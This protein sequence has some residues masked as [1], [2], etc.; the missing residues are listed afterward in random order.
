MK[1]RKF[2]SKNLINSNDMV[3]PL[4]LTFTVIIIAGYILTRFFAV[5][6]LEQTKEEAH[7]ITKQTV[8]G[9]TNTSYASKKINK[10][11]DEKIQVASKGVVRNQSRIS[12]E[13]LIGLAKDFE[14]DTLD[15]YN[16]QGVVIN[17]TTEEYL[18]WQ[19][20]EGHP[21]YDFMVSS[22][23]ELVEDIRQDTE[24]GIYYKFG[25]LKSLEGNFV[26]VGIIADKVN[27]LTEKFGIQNFVEE[28]ALGKD[29]LRARFIDKNLLVV[30]SSNKNEVGS[31]IFDEE[32]KTA[33]LAGQEYSETKLQENNVEEY[34]IVFPV[35]IE[36]E[37]IGVLSLFFSLEEARI[38]YNKISLVIVFLSVALIAILSSMILNI[39]RK[40]NRLE[41]LAY[42]DSLTNLPNKVYL[43][44]MLKDR[45]EKSS[46]DSKKALL[47]INCNNFRLINLMLGHE[48]GDNILIETA[49]RLSSLNLKPDQIF[50]F[51][52]DEFIFYLD[53]Y[54]D[55]NELITLCN[56]VVYLF[57]EPFQFNDITQNIMVSIGVVEVS[58][59]LKSI[60][61]L[62]KNGELALSQVKEGQPP[63]MFYNDSMR[64]E[65]IRNDTIE[66]GLR[67]AIYND[68]QELF[69]EYQPQI[70]LKTNKIIGVEALARWKSKDLGCVSPAEFIEIAENRQLIIPLGDWVLRAACKFIKEINNLGYEMT[71][72]VNISI[73]Q[74]LQ[75]DF[76]DKLLNIIKENDINAES[77]ELEITETIFMGEN[78]RLI[79]N[80][81]SRLKSHGFKIA[82]DD[83]GTGYSSLS[84]LKKIDIDTLKIDKF[85]IDNL[86]TESKDSV[87]TGAIILMAHQLDLVV[88]AEGVEVEEQKEY[89]KQSDCDIMQG[90]LFSRPV[91]KDNLLIY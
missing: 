62:L 56:E 10:L 27:K 7:N 31:E 64:E 61:E 46:N 32:F 33:I 19:A 91:S 41:H 45:L 38:L 77:V 51:T 83:F 66:K 63:Y 15:W 65:L 24:S 75:D 17:S 53:D 43:I 21:V 37:Y 57:E 20:Y 54:N 78:Y 4:I 29:I 36:D 14:V 47:F 49:N 18:G 6:L 22:D 11:L 5:F 1:L 12:D 48:T 60:N 8:I 86:L 52:A 69:L 40:K 42:Y 74:L 30:A 76:C 73:T 84:Y 67:K 28:L 80:V 55:R 59:A 88:V 71:V 72:A 3:L 70:N 13:F 90:Y 87:L 89:L 58:E 23:D 35:V 81:L 44:E 85:F 26:Q 34:K 25:Y 2:N 82:L 9:I 50:R 68:N 39:K 16:N 79:R